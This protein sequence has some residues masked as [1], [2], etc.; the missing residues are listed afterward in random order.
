MYDCLVP[1][2]ETPKVIHKVE[3]RGIYVHMGSLSLFDQDSTVRSCILPLRPVRDLPHIVNTMN[4]V[5]NYIGIVSSLYS[6]SAY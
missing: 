1:N 6:K 4:T 2:K 3:V 5:V